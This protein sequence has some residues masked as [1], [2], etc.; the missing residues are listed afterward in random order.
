MQFLLNNPQSVWNLALVAALLDELKNPISSSFSDYILTI[1]VYSAPTLTINVPNSVNVDVD[2]TNGSGG[3]VQLVLRAGNHAVSVPE[4]VE[5]NNTTRLRF[6]GWSDGV[7]EANRTVA[8]N[9]DVTLR[10]DYAT[11]YKLQVTSAVTIRGGGWYDSGT[12][13]HLS[14]ASGTVPMNGLLGAIGAKWILRGWVED[15]A[16]VSNSTSATISMNSPHEVIVIWQADY[17][18]PL[19]LGAVVA[20]AA[21]SSALYYKKRSRTKRTQTRRHQGRRTRG[22]RKFPFSLRS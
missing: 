20:L 5:V 11:Q 21:V 18:W 15:G 12:T 6:S 22:N 2:G 7:T 9:W 10:A 19:F 17:T 14:S 3:S 4:I 1:T 16:R 13:V 8:L